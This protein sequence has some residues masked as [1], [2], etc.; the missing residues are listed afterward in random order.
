M[1]VP[2]PSS[3]SSRSHPFLSH[4]YHTS[5][6]HHHHHNHPSL[7]LFWCLVFSLLSPLALSSSSSS[8]S[9]SSDSSSSSS[10]H[11]SLGIGETEG[12]KHDLH[13][14]IL[15]DE[16]VA[17]LHELGQVSDAATHL[18]RTFMSPASIRAI[19]LIRGWMEDAGLSTWVD[20]MGNVHGRVEPKNGS[21]QAL[22]IGSHMD[23]VIDA[24]KYD[25]S[26]GIISAISALKVLKIDGR[27][28]ELKR[29][30]E[31]IAFSDEEGVRFQSTFLGS[32]ALAGIM[33]V[34]RLE[35]TD[36]SGISVQDALKENSIDITDENLMQLKYDPASV[37]GYVEV[38]IEQGPVLEWVGYPLG[39]VKGIAGQTRLKVTVKGSQGHAGTVPMSMRQDPMTGAAELIVLL[40]SVCKNPKDYLSCNVQCNEDTVESLANSLVCTVGEISTWPS[41]SNVIPGQVTFT[42]D[43]RTIDDVGRKAILHDLSTRM[44][45]ICDKRSLLCSIERKHDADA[46]MSDPQLS[47]QLKSAAQSALKKMTG[48]VQDEVPVLMSGA[49]HDAMAMAHLTK[50]GMLFVRCRGGISHSPAEHVLDDDVGAAG[51]AILEFLESQ[52]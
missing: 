13:Q 49:G 4:V 1:A 23:T 38:H 24:G 21:S 5:F 20:Y 17:R 7:V 45:Q 47:L 9:S 44:Y 37:W 41:A 51:L 48:E 35:V 52:M 2:H 34:S 25:G 14:A 28:G 6:H 26:L 32:A 3:S 33:P 31:V 46:V 50:V 30:V 43:L 16:A 19:P 27:L 42:V 29:P 36:K 10:S 8:S 15:R 18:E 40:E 39:V 22:L 12:T 11:I